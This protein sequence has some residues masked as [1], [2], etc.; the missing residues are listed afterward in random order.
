MMK[1]AT[2]HGAG[3]GGGA[4]SRDGG[5]TVI[6]GGTVTAKS[7]DASTAYG[8]DIGGGERSIMGNR[9]ILT[10]TS[11]GDRLLGD[12]VLTDSMEISIPAGNTLVIPEGASLTVPRGGTLINDGKIENRGVFTV[13]GMLT[14]NLEIDNIGRFVNEGTVQ[15]PH[16][17]YNSGLISGQGALRGNS[18]IAGSGMGAGTGIVVPVVRGAVSVPAANG[19]VRLDGVVKG[20]HAT[21]LPLARANQD[22]NKMVDFGPYLTKQRTVDMDASGLGGVQSVSFP[23]YLLEVFGDLGGRE[24]HRVEQGRFLRPSRVRHAAGDGCN[25]LKLRRL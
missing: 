20:T 18:P 19:R 16:T 14:N 6:T 12:V 22:V 24:R 15:N 23:V 7:S 5:T 21:L 25:D 8:A 13:Y 10:G 11:S 9:L 1:G 4:T 17:I 2:G 3:I